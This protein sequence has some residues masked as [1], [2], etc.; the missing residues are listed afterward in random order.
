MTC[1]NWVNS[2]ANFDKDKIIKLAE[3]YP[4]EFDDNKLRDLNFQLDSFFDYARTCDSKFVNLKKI[5]DLVIVM[6]KTKLDQ[7]WCH[8]YLLMKL[9]LILHVATASVE[10]AFSSMKLIKNDLRNSISE[11]FW[12][13]TSFWW[14]NN[15]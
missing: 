12:I 8:V 4:S 2:F 13:N 5:K 11:E 9:T 3:Y 1:L 6:A 15:G 7:T 14:M 10:R